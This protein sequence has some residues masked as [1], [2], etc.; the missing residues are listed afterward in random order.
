M[1]VIKH[2]G[3]WICFVTIDHFKAA[4]GKSDLG[5]PFALLTCELSNTLNWKTPALSS[6][7][8]CSKAVVCKSALM[9]KS[10]VLQEIG[11]CLAFCGRMHFNFHDLIFG[12]IRPLNKVLKT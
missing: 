3:Q 7:G 11:S 2:L 12:K 6:S 8:R 4:N 5:C 9:A 10:F 1:F